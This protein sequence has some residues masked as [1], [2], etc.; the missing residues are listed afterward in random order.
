MSTAILQQQH[1]DCSTF[2][3]ED[4]LI[5]KY[6]RSKQWK[7][8]FAKGSE[9]KFWFI[10]L[11]EI[12]VMPDTKCPVPCSTNPPVM[13]AKSGRDSPAA[14]AETIGPHYRPMQQSLEGDLKLSRCNDEMWLAEP[15]EHEK[16]PSSVTTNDEPRA[17][18]LKTTRLVEGV[19]GPIGGG[20]SAGMNTWWRDLC[21][22]HFRKL[23]WWHF[24][25]C[26]HLALFCYPLNYNIHHSLFLLFSYDTNN[27]NKFVDEYSCAFL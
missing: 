5:S 11:R 6:T 7:L 18:P 25:R 20:I 1:G 19:C 13:K 10:F 22:L 2:T 14:A 21:P 24:G 23:W 8:Q 12:A 9:L 16:H 3:L 26:F 4:D 27:P 17:T 15:S